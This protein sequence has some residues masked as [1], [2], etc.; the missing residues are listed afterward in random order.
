[1]E[2]RVVT[3]KRNNHILNVFMNG[4]LIGKLE[5]IAKVR[6]HLLMINIG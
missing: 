4:I 2:S 1:M 6:L 3:M 5:K